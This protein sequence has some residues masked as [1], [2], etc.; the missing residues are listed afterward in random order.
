[1]CHRNNHKSFSHH[2]LKTDAECFQQPEPNSKPPNTIDLPNVSLLAQFFFIW[3]IST[4]NSLIFNSLRLQSPDFIYF[5]AFLFHAVILYQM[6]LK[7]WHREKVRPIRPIQLPPHILSHQQ[8]RTGGKNG[9]F[10]RYWGPFLFF[11]P[12]VFQETLGGKF[13]E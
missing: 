5:R 13:G 1:M 7:M 9:A 3:K 4:G 12:R 2:L 6:N 8:K 11:C 10:L